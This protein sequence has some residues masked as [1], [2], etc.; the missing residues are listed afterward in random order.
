MPQFLEYIEENCW[1][2]IPSLPEYQVSK[3]GYVRFAPVGFCRYV[4]DRHECK[5]YWRVTINH[6]QYFIHRLVCETF[7]G[8]SPAPKHQVAHWDGVKK[9][10]H[11][12]NL[13]WATHHENMMDKYRH[14]T[15]RGAHA[16]EKHH[17]AKLTAKEAKQIFLSLAPTKYL[18]DAHG[19]A[20]KTIQDIK[21]RRSWN[22]IHKSTEKN[23]PQLNS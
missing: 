12:T 8:A 2:Q 21:A 22:C 11:P 18:A 16:G 5:G 15:M 1:K 19:V 17:G 10:N 6:A 3:A 4:L 20:P 13:R 7:H 23:L 9:N 14:G